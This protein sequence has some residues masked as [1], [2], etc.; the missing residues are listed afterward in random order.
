MIVPDK[1]KLIF[2]LIYVCSIIK[3]FSSIPSNEYLVIFFSEKIGTFFFFFFFFNLDSNSTDV[4]TT[5]QIANESVLP[6]VMAWCLVP[7]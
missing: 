3:F 2:D 6:R 7:E 5:V 4:F 1:P